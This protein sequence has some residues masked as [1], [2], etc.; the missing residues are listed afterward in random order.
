MR[1]RNPDIKF[2]TEDIAF[3]NPHSTGWAL[4]NGQVKI[5]N[6]GYNHDQ[7]I[8]WDVFENEALMSRAAAYKMMDEVGEDP[9]AFVTQYLHWIAIGSPFQARTAYPP[10]PKALEALAF[11]LASAAIWFA[12]RGKDLLNAD[13]NLYDLHTRDPDS[14]RRVIGDVIAHHAAPGVESAMYSVLETLPY[15]T[16]LAE[17]KIKRNSAMRLRLSSVAR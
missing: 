4:S 10:S 11:Y 8:P 16:G 9:A 13:F 1:R 6:V 7:D 5:L 2:I 17:P 12:R 3:Q 14:G 15:P